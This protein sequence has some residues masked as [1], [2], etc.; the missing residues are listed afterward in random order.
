MRSTLTRLLA[1]MMVGAFFLV[2]SSRIDWKTSKGT[3]K[4]PPERVNLNDPETYYDRQPGREGSI[5]EV[6]DAH[7]M[8]I[9][10][11]SFPLRAPSCLGL[12]PFYQ[13]QATSL[14]LWQEFN[15]DDSD[16]RG[17]YE[18]GRLSVDSERFIIDAMIR[19]RQT[20]AE[21]GP[22]GETVTFNRSS[23]RVMEAPYVAY[24]HTNSWPSREYEVFAVS[25]GWYAYLDIVQPMLGN[26]RNSPS[27]EINSLLPLV[28]D[29]LDSTFDTS[30]KAVD[31]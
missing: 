27:S 22:G 25:K 1:I 10:Q 18:F 29:D 31:S 6:G 14:A 2:L 17:V 30:F 9:G 7:L 28:L 21:R 19:S 23:R 12:L 24:E 5:V 15:F 8:P 4:L 20:C 26:S 3:F 11:R 16:T 13:L